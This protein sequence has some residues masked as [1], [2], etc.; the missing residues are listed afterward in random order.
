ME[1]EASYFQTL[2]CWLQSFLRTVR[3]KRGEADL[4]AKIHCMLNPA[5]PIQEAD[6]T[7]FAPRTANKQALSQ[8]TH[9]R[10]SSTYEF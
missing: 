7:A 3:L 1:K 6:L 8:P 5:L 9:K 10:Q 4:Q 2:R